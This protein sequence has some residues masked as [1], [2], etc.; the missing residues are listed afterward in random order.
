[1]STKNASATQVNARTWSGPSGAGRRWMVIEDTEPADTA[2]LL[3]VY[4]DDGDGPGVLLGADQLREVAADL[5]ARADLIEGK[6]GR[7]A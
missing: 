5:I 4:D 1:M 7:S 2:A 3:S 6:P